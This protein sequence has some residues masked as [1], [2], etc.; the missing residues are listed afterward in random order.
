MEGLK[1]RLLATCILC[2]AEESVISSC[3]RVRLMGNYFKGNYPN[4][5]FVISALWK[6]NLYY[7]LTS[8]KM[9][10]LNTSFSTVFWPWHHHTQ[11]QGLLKV[12]ESG[13]E[14]PLCPSLATVQVCL[15]I[16]TA[17]NQIHTEPF[18]P[19]QDLMHCLH[20]SWRH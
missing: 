20:K 19:K 6:H 12:L 13:V 9:C 10:T 1:K 16:S 3:V 15:N 5:R 7:N 4:A 2:S 17:V 8:S 14:S 18:A 11:P